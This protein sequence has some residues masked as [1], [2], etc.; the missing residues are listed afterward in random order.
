MQDKDTDNNKNK[1]KCL[2][3]IV[4]IQDM[5]LC[6]KGSDDVHSLHFVDLLLIRT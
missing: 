1:E 4:F 2:A 3:M 5:E 6:P